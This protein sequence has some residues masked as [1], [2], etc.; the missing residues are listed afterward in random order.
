MILSL[1]EL[2]AAE[3]KMAD[4]ERAVIKDNLGDLQDAGDRF[5]LRYAAKSMIDAASVA[6]ARGESNPT[7]AAP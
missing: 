3:K 4:D 6:I 7:G 2:I 1:D 5:I